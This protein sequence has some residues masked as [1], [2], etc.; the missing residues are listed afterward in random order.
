MGAEHALYFWIGSFFISMA[1]V[2]A[3]YLIFGFSGPNDTFIPLSS[4]EDKERFDED[5]NKKVGEVES[6][7]DEDEDVNSIS[8]EVE[9]NGVGQVEYKKKFSKRKTLRV[10][11]F[12]RICDEVTAITCSYSGH[13]NF[14]CT[15]CGADSSEVYVT[16]MGSEDD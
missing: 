7:E 4:E 13:G 15:K 1:V 8:E 16:L 14:E 10:S 3:I 12:C 6:T 9:T 11:Y 5:P 2:Y